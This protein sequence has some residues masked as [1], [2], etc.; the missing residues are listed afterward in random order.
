MK[1]FVF[2]ILIALFFSLPNFS[3]AT[4]ITIENIGKYS[5]VWTDLRFDIGPELT[6]YADYVINSEGSTNIQNYNN[7]LPISWTS[8]LIPGEIYISH[9]ITS[10]IENNFWFVGGTIAAA[11]MTISGVVGPYRPILDVTEYTYMTEINGKNFGATIKFNNGTP[12]P[13][14]EPS[15]VILCLF[16]ITLMFLNSYKK[17]SN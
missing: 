13:I 15:T 12:N 4:Y 5:I 17:L 16:G 10:L 14:P 8:P 7:I 11:G 3:Y 9:Q 6:G 2:T 1:K